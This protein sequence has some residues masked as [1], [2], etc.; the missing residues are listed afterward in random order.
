[1]IDIKVN[2]LG[3]GVLVYHIEESSLILKVQFSDE[4]K[5]RV[6]EDIDSIDI[7]RLLRNLSK[8]AFT[9]EEMRQ[10]P[11]KTAM[12]EAEGFKPLYISITLLKSYM[13]MNEKYS[14]VAAAGRYGITIYFDFFHEGYG[15]PWNKM[16]WKKKV[17]R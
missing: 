10:D 8:G 17:P 9:E 16:F 15:R 14:L 7:E 11:L 6:N 2:V 5:R 1:M 12:L 13:F 3:Y 4:F